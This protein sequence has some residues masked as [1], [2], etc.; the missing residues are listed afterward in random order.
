MRDIDRTQLAG[1][2]YGL[3]Q[4]AAVVDSEQLLDRVTDKAA[5]RSPQDGALR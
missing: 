1:T 5:N 4:L 2:T 3:Q